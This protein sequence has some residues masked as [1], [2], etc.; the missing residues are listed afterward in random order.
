MESKKVAPTSQCEKAGTIKIDYKGKMIS[1]TVLQFDFFSMLT[2]GRKHSSV[3]L[4]RVLHVSD[5]R[6]EIRYL[7]KYGIEV[8]D[9][10]HTH[11]KL[12]T[13]YKRYFIQ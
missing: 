1:L 9:E 6:S 10:W 5:P 13:R 4:M 12:G 11:P 7:R 8:S 2:D 3:E